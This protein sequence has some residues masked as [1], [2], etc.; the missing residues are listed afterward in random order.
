VERI[1]AQAGRA[2]EAVIPILRALQ[3]HYRYLP[4]AALRR[5][6]E[7]TEITPAAISGVATFYDLFRHRPAGQYT[8]GVCVGT[9]CHVKGADL[10]LAAFRRR[11]SLA[12]GED[13]DAARQFTLGTVSCLGCCTLAPVVQIEQTIYGHVRPADVGRV[14]DDFLARQSTVIPPPRREPRLDGAAAGEVR[15][16]LGSCCQA[17]GSARVLAAVEEALAT[18]GQPVRLRQV[19]CV[20]SCSQTPLVEVLLAD[21]QRHTYTNVEPEQA[22]RIIRRHFRPQGAWRRLRAGLTAGLDR[23]YR[24]D[25]ADGAL[26]RHPVGVRDQ[27]SVLAEFLRPQVHIATEACGEL[28]P[29]DFAGYVRG[30]GFEAYRRCVQGGDPTQVIAELTASGLR[31]RGGAGYPSGRKWQQ[32]RA[33]PG[34]IKFLVCNGDEGD[35]GAFM[36]RMLLESYPFRT[37]EGAAIAAWAIGAREGVLYIRTEYP[38]ALQRVRAALARLAEEGLLGEDILGR[39]WGLHLRLVEGAG[40]FVC[41]EETALLAS[42]EGRRGMPRLRPPY[43]AEAGLDGK[44]TL[45]NNVETL[46]NVPWI[47]RH[48]A[49]AFAA[50]GTAGSKGTKVFALAGKTARGGLIEV[51]MGIS[52]R[53]VVEGIG[54][55][56]AGGKAFKAEQIGGPSGGCVPA[57]LADTPIDYEAL[58]SV[59]AIMGSGGVVVL[60]E[61]DCMVE[62]AR[63]FLHFTQAQSCGRC[64]PCRVGTRRMLDLLEKLCAGK[65]KPGDVEA[66]EALAWTVKRLSL[67]GL[68][69]TAPN[70]VLSTIR[71]F[72]QEYEAHLAGVCPAARCTALIRYAITAR[73]IGCTRCAQGCPVGAITPRPFERQVINQDLCVRCNA[74]RATCPVDAVEVK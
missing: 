74:C 15:L 35:P 4:P 56:V 20:G 38:L 23:L 36:D 16:G 65:G 72:R 66:L 6:C 34:E 59:G 54:G 11:L 9:A 70:P 32:V 45:V 46:A 3:E 39:G 57:A 22:G 53:A 64:A 58:N 48:G 17:R 68:G 67:C 73:C 60:D 26:D 49:A 13:T 30:G 52:I 14:L 1:V 33:A 62:I 24:G 2:A 44:P 55:G 41:G 63:Y 69:Q 61:S 18:T 31:G 10:V 28:D 37:L 12:E 8:I 50:L 43:P 51:P 7:L 5:V 29:L 42:I 21:G 25:E 47:L 40:A 27:P 71:H 19:G